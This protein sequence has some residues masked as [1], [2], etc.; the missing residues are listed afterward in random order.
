[1]PT[2]DELLGLTEG[3]FLRALV[4]HLASAENFGFDGIWVNEHHFDAFGGMAPSLPAILSALSAKTRRVRIGTS[5]VLL[6]IYHPLQVAEALSMV[7]LM[8]G[9]R[10]EFGVGRGFVAHDYEVLG[11]PLE[12]ARER[13]NESLEVILKAW[14]QRPFSHHGRFF[15]FDNLQLW[16]WPE[17]RPHPPVWLAATS[18][19]ESFEW[20]GSQGYRLLTIGF[21]IR[22]EHLAECTRVYRDAWAAAGH[23]PEAYEIGTHYQVVVGEDGDEARQTAQRAT[24]RRV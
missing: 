10:L 2:Y 21:A 9:G 17:Q 7:D 15:N 1:M 11:I 22:R 20:I 24:T 4:D 5:T 16:P 13:M 3:E 12:E 19:H 8:S 23:P 18:N 14:T 6:P